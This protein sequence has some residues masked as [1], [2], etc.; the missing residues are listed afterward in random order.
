MRNGEQVET[1]PVDKWCYDENNAQEG[2]FHGWVFQDSDAYKW[3]EA[4]AYSLSL[5]WDDGLYEKANEVIDLICSAQM[6]DGYLD[7]LYIIKISLDR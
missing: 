6:D 2:A 3:L 5:E 1:Y 7:T 4:V